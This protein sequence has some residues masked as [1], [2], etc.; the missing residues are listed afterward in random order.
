MKGLILKDI[1]N[2]RRNVKML[3]LMLVIFGVIFIPQGGG[4][5]LIPIYVLLCSMMVVTTISFDDLAKWD[6]YALT[7]PVSRNDMVLSKYVVLAIFSLSGAVLGFLLSIVIGAFMGEIKLQEDLSITII[8]IAVS[9]VYGSIM[10]P[11]IYRF[12]VEKARIL[13]ILCFLLPTLLVIGGSAISESFGIPLSQYY[14]VIKSVLWALPVV[15]LL[16][17]IGSC[18]LSIAIYRKKEF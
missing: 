12:G 11:F 9:L 16:L 3:V 5:A 17:F 7:M 6:K 2:I 14:P 10:L 8:S 15:A 13:L 4:A 1:Y 18:F